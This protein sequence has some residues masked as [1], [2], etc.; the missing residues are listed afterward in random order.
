MII[1]AMDTI[2]KI[3]Q[4]S[5]KLNLKSEILQRPAKL[6][7]GSAYIDGFK[8]CLQKSFQYFLQLDADLSHSP[9]YIPKMLAKMEDFDFVVASRYVKGGGV[10]GWPLR[11]KIISYGGNLYAKIILKS[12]LNDLTG[13][14]N[15]W[16]RKVL[17]SIITDKKFSEGYA[18]Q[19]E[20]KTKAIK[21][22]YNFYEFPITFTDRIKGSS[23]MSKKI[24]LEAIKKVWTI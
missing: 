18:F 16:S 2:V 20:L 24:I 22:G 7:L 21:A 23:K 10:T 8:L 3:K 13:G 11:R 1:V 19:I 6:G 15:L 4:I 17:E 9:D 12:P 14:F 5:S